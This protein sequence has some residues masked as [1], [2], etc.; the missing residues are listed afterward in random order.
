M[1]PNTGIK[2]SSPCDETHPQNMTATCFLSSLLPV[3]PPLAHKMQ[4]NNV[5]FVVSGGHANEISLL[6][7]FLHNCGRADVSF[8]QFKKIKQNNRISLTFP[9]SQKNTWSNLIFKLKYDL[10][11]SNR[12]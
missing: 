12:N 8:K 7:A 2:A 11:K 3:K 9:K 6:K 1:V 5:F 4:K 10:K